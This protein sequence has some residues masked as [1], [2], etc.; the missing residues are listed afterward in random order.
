MKW[1]RIDISGNVVGN[2]AG[3]FS[4]GKWSLRVTV[5]C[6]FRSCASLFTRWLIL[7]FCCLDRAAVFSVRNCCS[8]STVVWFWVY[9]VD[10]TSWLFFPWRTG[11]I[12]DVGIDID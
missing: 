2:R 3:G 10:R 4:K 9:D 7:L 5:P 12:V 6:D 1:V 11:M 8:N